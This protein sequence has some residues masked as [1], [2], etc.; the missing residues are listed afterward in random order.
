MAK[1]SFSPA[2]LTGKITVKRRSETPDGLG[3]F[4]GGYVTVASGIPA[5]V[6]TLKGGEQ[7]R[8]Q[9][10]ASISNFEIVVRSD[11]LTRT[12]KASDQLV[13]ERTSTV[14]DVKHIAN[15]DERDR[16]LVISAVAVS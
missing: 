15:L 13:N 8:M 3:N 9:R 16:W 10:L 1:P 7:V 2:D 11:G 14:L 12:I 6:S 5:R 4:R